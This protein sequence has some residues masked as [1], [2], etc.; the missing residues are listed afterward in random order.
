MRLQKPTL[1]TEWNT[2]RKSSVK[3][4]DVPVKLQCASCSQI[5]INAFKLPCCAQAV[6]E[7]CL[8]TSACRYCF[9]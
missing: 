3:R 8:K 4:E 5:N 6:C 7:K 1:Q 2:D 9:S